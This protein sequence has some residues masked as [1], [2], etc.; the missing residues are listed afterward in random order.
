VGFGIR[1]SGFIRHSSFVIRH[2]TS[3]MIHLR[4]NGSRISVP[5]GTLVASAIARV[6]V[7]KFRSSVLGQPRGPLCGMGICMEC[8]VTINGLAHCRSC[9]V[10]CSPDMD[11]RTDAPERGLL[12]AQ[13]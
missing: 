8:R 13:S 10:L 9:L 11:V 6:G 3:S 12:Q 1:H 2:L 4:I 5:E 7:T